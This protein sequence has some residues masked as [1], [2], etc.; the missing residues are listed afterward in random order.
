VKRGQPDSLSGVVQGVKPWSRLNASEGKGGAGKRC[1]RKRTPRGNG[2]ERG[3]GDALGGQAA[4][5]LQV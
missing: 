1:G 4:D 5:C 2:G 3:G